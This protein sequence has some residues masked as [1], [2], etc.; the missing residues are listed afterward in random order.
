[1]SREYNLEALRDQV[2]M[3]SAEKRSLYRNDLR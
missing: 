3:V 2:S 1:M